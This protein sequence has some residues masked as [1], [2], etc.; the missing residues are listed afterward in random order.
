MKGFVIPPGY[1]LLKRRLEH[2]RNSIDAAL[3]Q[4]SEGAVVEDDLVEGE[5][6]DDRG[7]D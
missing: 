7:P 1:E 4:L 2:C 3:R 6:Q 5:D